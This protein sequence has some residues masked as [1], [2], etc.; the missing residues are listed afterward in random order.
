MNQVPIENKV[1][2]LPTDPRQCNE[3]MRRDI[4][5][6]NRVLRRDAKEVGRCPAGWTVLERKINRLRLEGNRCVVRGSCL[7]SQWPVKQLN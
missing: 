5:L 1:G 7:V 6:L 4:N 2:L 3:E